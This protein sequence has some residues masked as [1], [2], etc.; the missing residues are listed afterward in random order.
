M[1]APEPL[2]EVNLFVF[3][4]DVEAVA[5]TLARLEV[6][7]LE[8]VKSESWIPDPEWPGTMDRYQNMVQK[9]E[10]LMAALR[11]PAQDT[12]LPEH[13]RPRKDWETINAQLKEMEEQVSQ[14]REQV[15]TTGKEMERLEVSC[16]QVRMLM[17]VEVS[18]A[19]LRD[20]QHQHLV[21]G[22]LPSENLERVG[23]ALFQIAFVLI[24]LYARKGR[25]VILSACSQQDAPILDRA[26]K[27]AFFE[28]IELPPEAH[29]P[30]Q[31][32]LPLLEDRLRQT[33]E[34]IDRL[35]LDRKL[36]AERLGPELNRLRAFA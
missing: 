17:P 16:S 2:Q 5:D 27:S 24:P 29:G 3:D 22:T 26:L 25:T 36:L 33:R 21:V 32:A 18:L 7:H 8:D 19:E 4:R 6:L 1:L 10:D 9:L 15:K 12:P 34:N 31:E 13:L 30:P 28:Q 11:I 35:E 20:F 23:A 14:W